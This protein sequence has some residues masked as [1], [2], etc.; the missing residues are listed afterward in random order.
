MTQV[1]LEQQDTKSVSNSAGKLAGRRTFHVYDDETAITSSATIAFGQNGLPAIGDRFPD[2]SL[3]FAE[4]YAINHLPDSNYVWRVEISYSSG[5]G[6]GR[7]VVTPDVV[8]YLQ[9][10]LDYGG[11]FKDWWRAPTFSNNQANGIDIG[12][13]KIDAAGIPLSF[14]VA[15]H[16]MILEE[17]VLTSSVA[18]RT[19]FIRAYVASRNSRPFFGAETGTLLYEGASARRIGLTTFSI[20]HKFLYDGFYHQSQQPRMNAN[21]EPIIEMASQPFASWVRWVQ[22]YT[23]LGNFALLSENF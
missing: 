2:D 19:A 17:T 4:S 10:S 11:Q 12:G 5:G 20:T 21:R 15:Q 8:G 1:A 16:R 14:F 22:P 23:S 9:I 7:D 6:A 13:Q 18:N 3:L